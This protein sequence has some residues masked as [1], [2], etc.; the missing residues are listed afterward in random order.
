MPDQSQTAPQPVPVPATQSEAPKPDE[1]QPVPDGTV[2]VDGK[3][4]APSQSDK[5]PVEAWAEKKGLAPQWLAQ[6]PFQV[7]PDGV[8]R[9]VQPPPKLNPN[10]W[11]FAA[12]RALRSWSIGAEV[13]EKDF[14]EAIHIAC[15]GRI[16]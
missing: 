1:P 16:G 4:V 8:V 6:P 7:N 3:P 14:D 2:I 13:T 10:W 11:K 12:A 15:N 5:R 9:T